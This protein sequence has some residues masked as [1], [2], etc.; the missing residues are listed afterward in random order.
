MKPIKSKFSSRH[1]I[2][3]TE[4]LWPPG[5][6]GICSS[7][8]SLVAKGLITSSL[9]VTRVPESSAE[10]FL[11]VHRNRAGWCR[12]C[13]TAR[14]CGSE[15]GDLRLSE[16]VGRGAIWQMHQCH[17]PDGRLHI[18]QTFEITLYTRQVGKRIA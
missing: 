6:R 14:G 7:A 8:H 17:L 13:L 18:C 1:D 9:T 15:A 11:Y 5:I 12:N 4:K 10:T 2:K 16:S 3:P